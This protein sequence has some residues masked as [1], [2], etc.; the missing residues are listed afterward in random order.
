MAF[1]SL[2]GLASAQAFHYLRYQ[3][4]LDIHSLSVVEFGNQRFR[5]SP[6]VIKK[7]ATIVGVDFAIPQSDPQFSDFTPYFFR[8]MGFNKY[9]ALDMNEKMEAIPV[10][11]NLDLRTSYRYSTEHS[12]VIDNGTGEHVF[13]QYMVFKNQHDL[14]AVGGLIL[15]IKPFLPW[16]NHGFYTFHPVLFRDLAYANGYK[17]V[18]TWLGG[19]HGEYVD[20]TGDDRIWYE[21][22]RSN[23]FWARPKDHLETL[24]YD[25]LMP[26][27]NISIVVAYQ[28]VQDK[29]FATPLQGKWVGNISDKNIKDKYSSQPDTLEKYHS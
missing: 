12:L 10:D 28:K 18:F 25:K 29:P 5:L 27:N 13:D 24:V 14:C 3:S 19:N 17:E 2:A 4:S 23:P 9:T 6:N 21:V 11:L 15:N 7:V 1:N 8:A 22:P 16:I 20:M 26:R